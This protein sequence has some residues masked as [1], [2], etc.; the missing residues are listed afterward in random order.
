MGIKLPERDTD[1]MNGGDIP[2]VPHMSSCHIAT[3]I[4]HKDNFTLIL[5]MC[6]L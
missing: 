1:F 2:P 3:L 5:M 6:I 4:K